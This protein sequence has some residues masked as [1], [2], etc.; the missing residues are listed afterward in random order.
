[1]ARRMRSSKSKLLDAHRADDHLPERR[2]QVDTVIDRRQQEPPGEGRIR[3]VLRKSDGKNQARTVRM[4][5]PS[6][7]TAT[8]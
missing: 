6:F 7:G 3:K 5:L 1:M 2:L 8:L 4:V